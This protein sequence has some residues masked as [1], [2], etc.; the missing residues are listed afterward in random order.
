M[1]SSA[2]CIQPV[3]NFMKIIGEEHLKIEVIGLT[4][5]SNG[6]DTRNDH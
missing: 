4:K 3:E 6:M 5:N 2:S 1:P